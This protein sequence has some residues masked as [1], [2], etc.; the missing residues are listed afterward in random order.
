M[1]IHS[2]MVEQ[3]ARLLFIK[4]E[5]EYEFARQFANNYYIVTIKLLKLSPCK[6]LQTLTK[7]FRR[8]TILSIVIIPLHIL[9]TCQT[10]RIDHCSNGQHGHISPASFPLFTTSTPPHP[11]PLHTPP[12]NN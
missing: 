4:F 5:K 6:L 9:I 7:L 2:L 1:N 10:D 8:S 3:T 12:M 11:P